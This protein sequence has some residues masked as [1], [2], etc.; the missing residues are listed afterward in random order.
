MIH[1]PLLRSVL[2]VPASNE[3]ALAKL[4]TL[5]MDAVILD[6]EDAV[7]PEWKDAARENL[8]VFFKARPRGPARFAIR[9]NG[10]DT[11]W[12]NEDFLAARACK[13]DAIVLPKVESP[14][15]ILT[16]SDALSETDAPEALKLWA[17]IETPR[18][19]MDLAAIAALGVHGKTRLEC[20]VAGTND[21][22]L[23]TGVKTR[24]AMMP[25][26]SQIV[27]AARAG[28]LAVID[29]PFNCFRSRD[30]LEAECGQGRDLGFD[31]KTLI[32]PDQIESANAIFAPSP[33]EI[34]DAQAIADAFARPE[35][36]NQNVLALNGKMVERLHL[37]IAETV[38]AKARDIREKME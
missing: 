34:A 15:D 33:E 27:L 21:L 35:N 23:G 13:P 31:G 20:L 6:L 25:W 19:V 30:G 36:A 18:G 8:R 11:E 38:L 2:Y 17:M 24:A 16:A 37:Q 4:A 28:G 32:H 22:M 3:R 12:G 7:A 14:Q 1:P 5:Q 26:L 10:F 9:I 29:G